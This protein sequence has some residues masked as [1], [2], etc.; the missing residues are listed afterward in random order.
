M[1]KKILIILVFVLWALPAMAEW[2]QDTAWVRR[3]DGPDHTDDW[4]EAIAVD[5]S[6]YCYVTGHSFGIGP[7]RDYATI[8]YKPN[9]DTAW[10]RRYDRADG[11]DWALALA[12]DRYRNAYVTGYTAQF[13]GCPTNIDYTTLKYTQNGVLAKGWPQIYEGPGQSDDYANDVVVDSSGNNIYVTGGSTGIGT[14]TDYATIRYNV[15]GGIVWGPKRYNGP[16]NSYDVATAVTVDRA[17]NVYVTGRSAQNTQSPFNFDYATIKYY[18]N[19]DT[20]WIR[21]YNGPSNGDDDAYAIAV[22]DSG[23]VYVTGTSGTIKYDANGNQLWVRTWGGVD[24]ALDKS[25]N[26]YVTGVGSGYTTVK[27]YPNGDTAWI[28]TYVGPAQLW[29]IAKAIA[30]DDSDNVYV[31]GGS[32]SS[33][34]WPLY[35]WDYATVKYD[36]NGNE[37]WV[38]RYDGPVEGL[39]LP[40]DI[41]IDKFYNVYVTGY[42]QVS[43]AWWLDYATI[44][45]VYVEFLRGDCNH[46]GIINMADVVYL[47][48]YLYRVGPAPYPWDAGDVDCDKDIDADDLD[49]LIAYLYQGGPPPGCP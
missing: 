1:H 39:D 32:A 13:A 6:G 36:S 37:L 35:Y 15:I 11:D 33:Y 34:S 12:V 38:R 7:D 2:T 14:Y 19:G 24:I 49:Y 40:F 30:L 17:G 42:S 26:V 3:Y 29:D 41:A 43:A 23:N 22:D 45:Y 20:A 31:T 27:Y 10:V 21:R 8:R 47:I 4:A 25:N 18:A 44:K 9:G 46:D 28:R 16:N 5:D 48:N